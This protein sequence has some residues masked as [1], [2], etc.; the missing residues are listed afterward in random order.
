MRLSAKTHKGK[1]VLKRWGDQ[2]EIIETRQSN[3]FIKAHKDISG[4]KNN[5]PDSVR[6]IKISEDP[7]FTIVD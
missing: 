6:W 3:L 4:N 2:W 7:D 5:L 1:N